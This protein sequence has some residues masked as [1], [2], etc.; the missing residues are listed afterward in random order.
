MTE[1]PNKTAA[2]MDI[3]VILGLV[4]VLVGGAFLAGRARRQRESAPPATAAAP[5]NDPERIV[6]PTLVT[7]REST[8][9]HP[10]VRRIRGLALA[11]D[12]RLFVAADFLIVEYDHEGNETRRFEVN[13][14]ARCLA[15]HPDGKSLYLGAGDHVDVLDLD[16]G[17]ISS[18]ASLGDNAFIASVAATDRLVIVGDSGYRK[19]WVF[20]TEGKILFEI[21][22]GGAAGTDANVPSTYFDVAAAADGTFWATDAGRH[23]VIHYSPEG[24]SLGH[25]GKAGNTIDAFGGCCNPTHLAVDTDNRI[26]TVEKKPDLV[27]VYDVSGRLEGVIAGPKAFTAKTFIPDL[28]VTAGQRV[29]LVDPKENAVRIFVPK[30]E[31]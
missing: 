31:G 6:D 13:T 16:N 11:A 20:D 8:G 19:L 26:Y 9:I 12:S 17:R 14:A 27:K 7:F 25:W 10:D 3:L 24:Q 21:A 23:G 28:A 5:V 30:D 18:W 29:Y 15:V 1:P 4:I 2:K 22:N